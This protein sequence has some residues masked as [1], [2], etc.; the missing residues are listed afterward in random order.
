MVLPA[1]A[2][3]MMRRMC[4]VGN[5]APAGTASVFCCGFLS[6]TATALRA[7]GMAVDR[8]G[9]LVVEPVLR[10]EAEFLGV[11]VFPGG[12]AQV[13][14]HRLGLAPIEFGDLA[15]LQRVAFAGAAGEIVEDAPA[16]R[17]DGARAVRLLQLE[18][19]DR[20]V[21]RQNDGAGGRRAGRRGGGRIK[22]RPSAAARRAA[23]GVGQWLASSRVSGWPPYGRHDSARCTKGAR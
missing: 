22:R 1:R 18:L 14:E 6:V 11:A 7:V 15:E 2:A 23:A 10:V 12:R 5:T 13:A 16:H 19:V 9:L 3:S 8:L 21:R 4:S 17:L 20:A